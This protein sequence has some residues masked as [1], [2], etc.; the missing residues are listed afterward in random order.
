MDIRDIFRYLP[1]QPDTEYTTRGGKP[2]VCFKFQVKDYY[3]TLYVT[4]TK[5]QELPPEVATSLAA[6]SLSVLAT[7]VT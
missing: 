1:N 7:K 5:S 2:G 6:W 3:V 4:G